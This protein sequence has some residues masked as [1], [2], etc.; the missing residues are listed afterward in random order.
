MSSSKK[1]EQLTESGSGWGIPV[2]EPEAPVMETAQAEPPETFAEFIQYRTSYEI[3]HETFQQ[4]V[5]T[6]PKRAYDV[7]YC[8]IDDHKVGTLI[9]PYARRLMAIP[10]FLLWK[11]RDWALEAVFGE[12]RAEKVEDY[13]VW[14]VDTTGGD[15]GC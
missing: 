14:C 10:G 8:N 3:T 7:V 12:P 6:L 9:A 4:I 13:Y 1:K 11:H 5:K 15:C 2:T